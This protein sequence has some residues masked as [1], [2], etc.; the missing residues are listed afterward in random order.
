MTEALQFW[1][2][3]AGKGGDEAPNEQKGLSHGKYISIYFLNAPIFLFLL[4]LTGLFFSNKFLMKKIL[5]QQRCQKRMSQKIQS[6]VREQSKQQR[7]HLMI[8]PLPQILFLNPK[9]LLQI[10]QLHF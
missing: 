5:N 10:K 3:I 7:V 2:K 9:V 1:K 6:L 4:S 8:H